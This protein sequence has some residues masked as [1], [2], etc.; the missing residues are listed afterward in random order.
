MGERTP[1]GQ[2]VVS[3]HD[4]R[5]DRVGCFVSALQ[6]FERF[7]LRADRSELFTHFVHLATCELTIAQGSVQLF[8]RVRL[9][10][11]SFEKRTIKII[12][13]ELELGA[14]LLERGKAR[15]RIGHLRISH[16]RAHL[17][18]VKLLFQRIER[19]L[20]RFAAI[21]ER[22]LFSQDR[23]DLLAQFVTLIYLLVI[24]L[25]DAVMIGYR[26]VIGSF[27]LLELRGKRFEILSSTFCLNL[28]VFER[29]N[30]H[31]KFL[32]VGLATFAQHDALRV[33]GLGD[34]THAAIIVSECRL[35][36]A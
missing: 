22:I 16:L 2:L 15:L 5:K 10:S 31:G 11:L 23:V 8:A 3:R 7:S 28:L 36:L 24:V 34:R 19:G 35:V 21:G 29:T 20:D 26:V 25:F 33:D 30:A 6:L 32:F 9:S 18:I 27:N 17:S 4:P 14:F 1:G 12:E 13:L